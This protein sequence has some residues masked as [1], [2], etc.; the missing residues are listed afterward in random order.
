MAATVPRQLH[1]SL[2]LEPFVGNHDG[3][4]NRER[5]RDGYIEC[6]QEHQYL[7]P[8]ELD[9]AHGLAK[10]HI[11]VQAKRMPAVNATILITP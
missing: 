5:E 11:H 1:A 8:F 7:H 4:E 10:Q 3:L 2:K 9:T 6:H